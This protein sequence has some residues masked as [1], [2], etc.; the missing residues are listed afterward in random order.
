M[1]AITGSRKSDNFT[2]IQMQ[3]LRNQ[4][5]TLRTQFDTFRHGDAI[6]ADAIGHNIA[7]ELGYNI[8]IHPPIDPKYRAFCQSDN[9]ETPADYIK[10]DHDFIDRSTLLLA[11]PNGNKEILRSGTWATVRYAR[12]KRIEIRILYPD[13]RVVIENAPS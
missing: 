9:I 12:K 6:G 7:V 1:L 4:L 11:V 10:R 3:H 13:G 5:T 8:I 2:N